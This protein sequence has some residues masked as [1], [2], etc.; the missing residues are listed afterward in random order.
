MTR[1]PKA[2]KNSKSNS[3]SNSSSFKTISSINRRP[4]AQLALQHSTP[5]RCTAH[6]I[7][8]RLA[9]AARTLRIT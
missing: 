5:R 8:R 7:T 6:R 1:A 4:T 9:A 3:N 2:T